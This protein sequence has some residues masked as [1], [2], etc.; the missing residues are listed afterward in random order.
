[1]VKKKRLSKRVT[2]KDKYKVKRKV[3]EHR[4]KQRKRAAQDERTGLAARRE[5]RKD[6]GVP[7]L[8]PD[9]E[10]LLRQLEARKAR[11]DGRK[12]RRT[13]ELKRARWGPSEEHLRAVAAASGGDAAAAAEGEEE[14]DD[15]D[16]QDGGAGASTDRARH[17]G[18]QLKVVVEE[19]DVVLEVLD[20]RDPQGTRS[21]EIEDMVFARGK[22]L[23]LVLN[24]T[25]LV[26]ERAV[27]GWM[28][29][30]RREYPT[31]PFR[32]NTQRQRAN[33][34]SAAGSDELLRLLKNY[35]RDAAGGK[36]S[37]VVGIV[38]APNVG[39]SSIVNSLKLERAV[40]TSANAGST[41]RAAHVQIDAKLV[42]I[43]SP[44]VV[45]DAFRGNARADAAVDALRVCLN[46]VG[47]SREDPVACVERLVAT[48]PAERVMELYG[49]PR[50]STPREFLV[51]LATKTGKLARGGVVRVEEAARAVINDCARGKLK[52]FVEPPA[53]DARDAAEAAAVASAAEAPVVLSAFSEEFVFA[54]DDSA[55]PLLDRALD[56]VEEREQRVERVE[57]EQRVQRVQRERGAGSDGGDGEDDDEMEVD[58]DEDA[59]HTAAASSTT[60]TTSAARSQKPR[61]RAA[62][63]GQGAR[64]G[65]RA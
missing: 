4:R 41:K 45:T 60:A 58:E 35:A 40:G 54:K 25:D 3:A 38:G 44:G 46:P 49:L 12:E 27:R 31:L 5:L 63:G 8:W 47:A 11:L 42:M 33:L 24:K 57:R 56:A 64:K 55:V 22:R 15:D 59:P 6:P 20:A 10:E 37:L 14:E 34:K 26:P 28:R 51:A 19:A 32:A 62:G 43:D 13:E 53:L 65:R 7:N 29:A 9:K 23:V 1:M 48:L 2:L 18:S 39:K 21:K 16:E 17:A 61:P 52:L 36:Q 30:L 50:F